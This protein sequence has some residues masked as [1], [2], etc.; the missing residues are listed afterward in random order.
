MNKTI[1]IHK[2]EIVGQKI[3]NEFIL[4][5]LKE[6][7]IDM[8]SI[9]RFNHTATSIWEKIDGKNTIAD[10][11]IWFSLEYGLDMKKADSEINK[12]IDKIQAFIVSMQ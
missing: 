10:L 7:V 9:F 1:Y 3:N 5:P 11:I 2:T 8:R 6:N 12:F 4:V